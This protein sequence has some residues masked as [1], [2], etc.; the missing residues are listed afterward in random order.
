MNNGIAI[1]GATSHIAKGLIYNFIKNKRAK[2]FLF[3]R[4][5]QRVKDLLN[6]NSL[7]GELNLNEFK[8]F[9]DR[10]YDVIINCTGMG[11]PNKLKD[12]RASIFSITEEFDKMV[13]DYLARFTQSRY[14]SFSSGAVY[15]ANSGNAVNGNSMY[16]ININ[17]IKPEEYYAI[18]KIN[19][20]AKHRAHNNFNIVD[21]RVFAYFS[22]FIDLNAGY[23]LTDLIK[24]IQEKKEFMTN[25][26]DFIRDYVHPQDLFSLVG[27]II[28]NNQ[29][30]GTVDAY[31]LDPV[32]KFTL[33]DYFVKKYGLKYAINE[34]LDIVSP[35][36]A[37]NIYC[38]Q[39]RGADKLGYKPE[40]SSF[41]AIVK[42][43]EFIL[44]S[45]H[46]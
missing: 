32:S 44:G 41:E 4:S 3:S 5:L 12:S 20:E 17:D 28:E 46:E 11:T 15:G 36:G 27:L 38:S 24:S 1:L 29:F 43:S 31:S 35:T 33:L 13:L 22:R 9:P 45:S 39:S 37:K 10:E 14:I 16:G 18:A 30:N 19:S 25:S 23:F 34:H 21:I 40:F 8:D 7:A 42:E 2:L 26:C 6:E